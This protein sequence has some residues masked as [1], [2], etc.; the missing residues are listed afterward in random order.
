[1]AAS[2]EVASSAPVLIPAGARIRVRLDQTLDTKYTRPGSTFS[3]TLEE[4]IVVGD[5]VVVPKGTPFEGAVVAA[6]T[7]G[8]F[9]GRGH[10]ELT[11]RSFRLHGV[12]YAVATAHDTRTTGN[13]KK[14]NL[15]LI[16]GGAGAGAGIGA[17]AGGG[18]GAL[19]GGGAGAVAG[20]TTEFITGKKN[21]RLP[22]E[23]EMVFR[24]RAPLQVRRG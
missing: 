13:H 12:R 2:V 23:T 4:P 15:A 20:T 8:R 6:K 10:L 9:K 11:L 1:V 22:A 18:V 21:V 3:A 14:R 17:I 19:I 24:L 5:R 7:S 16:G